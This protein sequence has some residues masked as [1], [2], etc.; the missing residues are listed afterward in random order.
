LRARSVAALYDVHGN[1]PALE[2]TLADVAPL[3]PDLVVV[4]G[5]VALGPMPRETL[6]RLSSLGREIRFVRGNSDREAAE[7]FG[8]HGGP[9]VA[10]RLGAEHRA[11]LARLPLTEEVDVD[12]LGRVVF[13]HATPRSDEELVTRATPESWVAKALA[14]VEA[15]VVVC[16]HVHVRYDRAVAGRRVVNPGSVGLPYEA[17]P[18]AYWALLGPAVSLRR[19]DYDVAA[20]VDA[21]RA[22][23]FPAA[24][25]M[26]AETLLTPPPPD[27]VTEYFERIARERR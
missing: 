5:D 16:G 12:G 6:E 24:E 15:D 4:G 17:E 1:L 25:E 22:T 11:F 23:G 8:D 9:W 18:G 21:I 14:D 27:E 19:T 10:E 7:G 2:A 3:E 13:C 20:A 26:F